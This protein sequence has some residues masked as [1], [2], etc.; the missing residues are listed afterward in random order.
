MQSK[1]ILP[2]FRDFLIL[3]TY[4]SYLYVGPIISLKS[5][6]SRAKLTNGLCSIHRD[7]SAKLYLYSASLSLL[8]PRYQDETGAA[9]LQGRQE[10]EKKI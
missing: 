6:Q 7:R 3:S 4:S 9:R 2:I 1:K 10:K 5:L 8:G